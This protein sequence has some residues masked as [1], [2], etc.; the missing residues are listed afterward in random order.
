[1]KIALA[2]RMLAGILLATTMATSG[3]ADKVKLR[4]DWVYGA[5]HAPIFLARDKGFF[6]DE[7]IDVELLPGEGSSVTVKLVGNG[8]AEFGYATADQ[9]LI[10]YSK[11]LPVVSTALIAQINPTALIFKTSKPIK[12]LKSDLYGKTIGV[13]MKSNTARQWTALKQSLGLDSSKFK[14]VPADGA[15][16]PLIASDRID[17]GIGFYYNDGLKLRATGEDVAWILFEDNGL[18]LYSSALITSAPLI[19]KNPDLVRRFTRA[20]VKG[21][22]YS[23]AHPDESLKAFLTAN[24]TT[25]QKYAQLKLPE[26]LRG[27]TVNDAAKGGIGASTDEGW[28]SMQALLLKMNMLDAPVDVSKAYTNRFLK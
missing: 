28:K 8:D 12:D 27:A 13:Q 22:V 16:V 23:V 9:A 10:A 25:D 3:A 14:E 11:G 6:R 18:K 19:E 15:L 1:M 21:W 26:I 7:G 2:A 20:F 5:E 24:P 4:L 17:V